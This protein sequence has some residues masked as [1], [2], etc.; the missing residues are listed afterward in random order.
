MTEF[1][2]VTDDYAVS[3]QIS[4]QDSS[5]PSISGCRG[6]FTASRTRSIAS[7]AWPTLPRPSIAPPAT[8]EIYNLERKPLVFSV[9]GFLAEATRG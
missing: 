3:P 1:R 8:A 2:R 4:P 5:I 7:T 9:F 6:G